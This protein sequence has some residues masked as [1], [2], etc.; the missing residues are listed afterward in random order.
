MPLWPET[1][2]SSLSPILS[3]SACA[4]LPS[5]IT[6]PTAGSNV[7]I[8]LV[9][10]IIPSVGPQIE[11]KVIQGHT[12]HSRSAWKRAGHL[13]VESQAEFGEIGIVRGTVGIWMARC[14]W[15]KR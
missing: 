4:G 9:F 10:M 13:R 7:L 12:F 15:A 2:E 1:A 8:S 6:I 5:V 11:N 3:S 14:A